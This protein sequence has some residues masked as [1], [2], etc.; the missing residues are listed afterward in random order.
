[1]TTS[2]SEPLEDRIKAEALRLGFDACGF[3]SV[4]DPWPASARLAEFV[5]NGRH[6]TMAWMETTAARRS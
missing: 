3:A 2:I 4:A 1:M 5:E 6:G